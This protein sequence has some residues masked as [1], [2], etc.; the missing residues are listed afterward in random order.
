[1][2]FIVMDRPLA[3]N[4]RYYSYRFD[5]TTSNIVTVPAGQHSSRN[6]PVKGTLWRWVIE[7]IGGFRNFIITAVLN[8]TAVTWNLTK[9]FPLLTCI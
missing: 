1:M 8:A 6:H 2:I 3:W 7:M 5:Q 9:S 4:F